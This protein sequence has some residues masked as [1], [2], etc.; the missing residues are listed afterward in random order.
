[1]H[2][3]CNAISFFYLIP[4]TIGC[5]F[6]GYLLGPCSMNEASV[7]S[8]EHHTQGEGRRGKHRVVVL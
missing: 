8:Q 5:H 6:L 2:V 1:M 4:I 7:G 3:E